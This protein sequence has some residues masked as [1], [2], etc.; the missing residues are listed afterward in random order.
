[1]DNGL[2]RCI[3]AGM[4]ALTGALALSACSSGSTSGSATSPTIGNVNCQSTP[5][6]CIP[7]VTATTVPS[8]YGCSGTHHFA[9]HQ[10]NLRIVAYGR[11]AYS[12]NDESEFGDLSGAMAEQVGGCIT[13]WTV[14]PNRISV[15]FSPSLPS[16]S[17]GLVT[18]WL[19]AQTTSV[20]HVVVRS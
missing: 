4:L 14:Q 2:F 11:N 7:Y 17:V 10:G 9:P 6:K 12:G 18:Q 15:Y 1:M 13:W 20:S 5:S 16:A 8:T 19:K 3:V